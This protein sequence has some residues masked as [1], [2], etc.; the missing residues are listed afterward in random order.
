V[1]CCVLAGNSRRAGSARM[2]RAVVAGPFS[3]QV[4]TVPI[5]AGMARRPASLSMWT[6]VAYSLRLFMAAGF[7]DGLGERD[8]PGFG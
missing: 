7:P 1:S 4:R 5:A 6:S 3:R 2:P 8:L